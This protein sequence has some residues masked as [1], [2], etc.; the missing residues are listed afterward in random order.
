MPSEHVEDTS[1][2]PNNN[3]DPSREDA[4][5]FTDTG[6]AHARVDFDPEVVTEGP[7]DFFDLLGEFTGGCQDQGLALDYIVVQLLEDS[8]AESCGFTGS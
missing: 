1:R 3:V 4:L 5:V 8:G 6:P 2:C 7:H